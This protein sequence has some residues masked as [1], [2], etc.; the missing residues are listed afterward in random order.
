MAAASDN[1]MVFASAGGQFGGFCPKTK[2]TTSADLSEYTVDHYDNVIV[3]A[4]PRP[5]NI[6]TG[7]FGK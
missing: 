2:V 4:E 7:C 3:I 1:S 6:T 5:I